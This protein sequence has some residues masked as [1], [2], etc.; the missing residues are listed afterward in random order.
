VI[1]PGGMLIEVEVVKKLATNVLVVAAPLT[2]SL[3]SET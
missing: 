1:G 3:Y 2:L